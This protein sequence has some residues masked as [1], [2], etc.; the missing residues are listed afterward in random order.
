MSEKIISKIKT[1]D[2]SKRSGFI[3]KVVGISERDFYFKESNLIGITFEKL[4]KGMDVKFNPII[5][6]DSINFA[7]DIELLAPIGL[8]QSKIKNINQEKESG[9]ISNIDGQKDIYFKKSNLVSELNFSDL[10]LGDTVYFEIRI[11]K[12]GFLSAINVSKTKEPEIKNSISI[13]NT[14]SNIIKTIRNNAD[15]I[16]DPYVFEDYCFMIIKLLGLTDAYQ[17]PRA[18]QAGN[19][20]G[21]FKIKALEVLYDCTLSEFYQEYKKDQIENYIGKLNKTQITIDKKEISLNT[22]N[23]KQVWIITKGKTQI[24]KDSDNILVKEISLNSLIDLLED[25]LSNLGHDSLM[26]KLQELGE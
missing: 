16:T 17:Y 15:Y 12:D 2:E 18:K 8:Q 26:I 3:Y 13:Q 21:F 1:L 24:I 14:I 7:N 10:S 6:K 5:S 22:T 19:A 4:S 9:F 20:D 11:G 25:R 23:N